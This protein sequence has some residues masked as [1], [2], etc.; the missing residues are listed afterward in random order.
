MS[1]RMRHSCLTTTL[2]Y[3]VE[4][5]AEQT[6]KAIL[7]TLEARGGTLGDTGQDQAS[8]ESD[9]DRGKSLHSR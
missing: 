2:D 1:T 7:G 6:A 9:E 5:D 4:A 3:Y 8:E